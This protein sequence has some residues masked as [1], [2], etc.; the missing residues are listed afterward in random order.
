MRSK[1]LCECCRFHLAEVWFEDEAFC[2]TCRDRELTLMPR[3]SQDD[4][5]IDGWDYD[6]ADFEDALPIDD[7]FLFERHL[8]LLISQTSR[9]ARACRR[10]KAS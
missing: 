4:P 10:R 8:Q 7:R 3:P 5:Y 9:P 2:R 6:D 1:L